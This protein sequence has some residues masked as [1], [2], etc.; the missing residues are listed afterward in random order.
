M[1]IKVRV[2]AQIDASLRSAFRPLVQSAIE[3]RRQIMREFAPVPKEIA[4]SFAQLGR[5]GSTFR[6]VTVEAQRANREIVA[7]ARAS[8]REQQ[9]IARELERQ[10]VTATRM[11]HTEMRREHATYEREQRASERRMAR[12]AAVSARS[13]QRE[14]ESFGRRTSYRAVQIARPFASTARRASGEIA[15]GFGVDP[16]VAGAFQ[17]NIGLETLAVETSNSARLAGQDISPADIQR[18]VREVSNRRSMTRE[19]TASGLLAFQKKTGDAQMGL[20]LLDKMAERSAATG[21]SVTDFAGAMAS[22]ST[23]LGDMPNKAQALLDIMDAITVQGARGAVEVSDL[24]KHFSR[25]AAAS[26]TFGGNQVENMKTLGALAQISMGQGGAPSAAEAVR[27]VTGFSN[28]FKKSARLKEFE[29]ITGK[30]AFSDG[31]KTTLRDPV[32]L[33][34]DALVGTGG[35][36]E[37]MNHI[38]MDTIGARAVTGFTRAY[39]TAGG[40]EK[41]LGAVDAL[42][43]KFTDNSK[44]SQALLDE[45][46][47]KR[48]ETTAAKVQRFQN[49]LDDTAQKVQASLLPALEKLAPVITRVAE[50]LGKM[51]QYGLENPGKAIT[52]AIIAS[53]ARAGLETAMR[54]AIERSV[55]AAAGAAGGGGAGG[56]AGGGMRNKLV[57]GLGAAAVGLALGVPLYAAIMAA[58][59]SDHEENEAA[60]RQGGRL[61]VDVQNAAANAKKINP[62]MREKLRRRVLD[63]EESIKEADKKRENAGLWEYATT[64]GLQSQKES[65][66]SRRD[67]LG[68]SRSALAAMDAVKFEA[69]DEVNRWRAKDSSTTP[70]QMRA[71]FEKG[72]TAALEKIAT[73][74]DTQANYAQQML[75]EQRNTNDNLQELIAVVAPP[76]SGNDPSVDPSSP[77][78]QQ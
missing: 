15:R 69:P 32:S 25:I 60:T 64:W 19:D 74:A 37:K 31:S 66:A 78:Y 4:A 8:A 14:V 45:S 62:H 40:G 75:E 22:A 18:R 38:F 42:L 13:A 5:S 7:S 20:D 3:A 57:G 21:T 1:E 77:G 48:D 10:R 43:A 26:G 17:R 44:L 41:G 56:A 53:I 29:G 24:A 70:A 12:E 27:S 67:M 54:S 30:S 63:E 50:I 11:G 9:Q 51:A 47:A 6:G 33:I 72:G 52:M 39:N 71:A 28:T 68:K 16:T 49:A 59:V 34:K 58:G 73:K 35:N 65:I 23:A 55:A 61:Q 2:G 46:N 76:G 36:L